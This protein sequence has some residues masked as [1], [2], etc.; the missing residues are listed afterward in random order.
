M[1][2]IIIIVWCFYLLK[3]ILTKKRPNNDNNNNHLFLNNIINKSLTN[4]LLD[5]K[6]NISNTIHKEKIEILLIFWILCWVIIQK[7]KIKKQR[8]KLNEN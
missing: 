7:V 8:Q 2:W 1:S 6:N 3:K 5:K 4:I